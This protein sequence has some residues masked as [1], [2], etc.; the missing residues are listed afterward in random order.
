[1]PKTLSK[2][3]IR[4]PVRILK[5]HGDEYGRLEDREQCLAFNRA[6]KPFP[7]T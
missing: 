4:E 1:M 3:V 5:S 7:L 6:S 2:P